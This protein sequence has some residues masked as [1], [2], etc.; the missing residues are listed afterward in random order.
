MARRDDSLQ[1]RLESDLTEL[2]L[3]VVA[4]NYREVLD[5][6]ARKGSSLL[7]VLAILIGLEQAAREQR[8]LDRRL[9]E[10]RLPKQKTLAEYDFKFPKRIPKAAILR[11]FDCDFIE[12]HGCAVLIGPTGTGKSHLLTALGYAA[13][14]RGH[15]VRHTRAVDMINHLTGAQLNGSLDKTLKS[16]VRPSLLLLDELGYLPIDKRGADLLFQVVAARYEVGSIVITTNRPFREWG[17][18]FDVDNTLATA[19]IDRL[20]HH[21]EGLVIQGASYRMKDK[22]PDSTDQ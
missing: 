22:D 7:E 4:R 21:G 16:Y 12:Q 2:K 18:L 19:L 14:E 3:L 9:R 11:L 15:S 10:A 1:V 6:A 17:K 5:E 20:M 13:V 8:A